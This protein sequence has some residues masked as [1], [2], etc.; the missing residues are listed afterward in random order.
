MT[1]ADRV[2]QASGP[3]TRE[4]LIE[5]WRSL[6][7]GC[8]ADLSPLVSGSETEGQ[9]VNRRAFRRKLDA[10]S[11]VS[12]ALALLPENYG[13]QIH[14]PSIPEPDNMPSARVWG[15]LATTAQATASTPALAC[16]A[17]ILRAALKGQD[18]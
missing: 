10:G 8:H 5:A 16:L 3:K 11:Y 15:S 9:R 7:P 18:A 4:L 14:S 17:A 1:L 2:E 13:F 12:A 6:H